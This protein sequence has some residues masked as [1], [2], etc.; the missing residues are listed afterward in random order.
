MLHADGLDFTLCPELFRAFQNPD[1]HM[2]DSMLSRLSPSLRSAVLIVTCDRAELYTEGEADCRELLA[3][4][5]GLRYLEVSRYMYQVRENA[6]KHLLLLSSGII[7]PLFGE[8]TIIS[9][10]GLAMERSRLAGLSD[11]YLSRLFGTAVAFGK[12]MQTEHRLRVVDSTIADGVSVRIKDGSRVLV[13][14]SG[15]GARSI[16]ERLKARCDVSMTLRDTAKVFLLPVGVKAVSYDDRLAAA[17][18]CD[19]VISFSSGLY[20]TFG[21]EDREALSGKLLFDLAMP[22]DMPGDFGAMTIES[23]GIELP[24]RKRVERIVNEEADKEIGSFFHRMENARI[25][26]DVSM[27][28]ENAASEALRRLSG[29]LRGL[30]LE[31]GKEEAF[32]SALHDSIRKAFISTAMGSRKQ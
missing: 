22:R 23:M 2:I 12:R 19:A 30:G 13:V 27:M 5:M 18:S 20:H 8:D 1:S 29:P 4:A 3:R 25:I 31:P 7:S 10:V 6:E 26:G 17:S 24:E 15:E 11:S 32:R 21:D 28:A 16:A 9:Q 14:G